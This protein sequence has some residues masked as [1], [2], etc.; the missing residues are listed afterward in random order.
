MVDGVVHPAYIRNMMHLSDFMA[1]KN[2]EGRRWRDDELAPLIKRDRATVSRIRRGKMRPDWE[3]IRLIDKVTNGLV[4]A[5]DFVT[6]P[7][8]R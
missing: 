4:Q 5:N 6:L 1:G 7:G 8:G 3:T 2:P